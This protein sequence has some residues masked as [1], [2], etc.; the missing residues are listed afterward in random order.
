MVCD[1]ELVMMIALRRLGLVCLLALMV[2]AP[3][4]RAVAPQPTRSIFPDFIRLPSF[5]VAAQPPVTEGQAVRFLVTLRDQAGRGATFAYRFEDPSGALTDASAGTLTIALGQRFGTV[6]RATRDDDLVNGE[7]KVTLF[8]RPV[9]NSGEAGATA[10]ERKATATIRDNDRAVSPPVSPPASPTTVP[11]AVP[12]VTIA[13]AAM[14]TEGQTLSFPLRLSPPGDQPVSVSYRLVDQTG[15]LAGPVSGTVTLAA[16]QSTGR[17]AVR[18]R[19]NGAVNS[20]RTI[21]VELLRASTAKIGEPRTAGGIVADAGV[22]PTPEP[23]DPATADPAPSGTPSEASE[24]ASPSASPSAS[25]IPSETPDQPPSSDP[26]TPS[27]SATQTPPPG[28]TGDGNGGADPPGSGIPLWPFAAVA[29]LAALLAA[30]YAALR[31]LLRADCSARIAAEGAE[32]AA[33]PTIAAPEISLSAQARA[34]EPELLELSGL[35]AKE[36]NA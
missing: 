26:A 18:T 33:A 32:L 30:A 25:A 6:A 29:A 22:A 10:G 31:L 7:R 5:I 2:L 20:G 8:V 14:V 15:T 13:N 23:S 24:A 3:P 9:S 28:P 35:V 17:I 11:N 4:S 12:V 27:P 1:A 21:R 34:G 36:T 16:R 19:D